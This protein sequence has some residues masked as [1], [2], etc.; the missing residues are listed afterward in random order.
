MSLR[1]S[2][3]NSLNTQGMYQMLRTL[4]AAQR[5]NVAK[6]SQ[7]VEPISKIS[8]KPSGSVQYT[9]TLKFVQKYGKDMSDVKLSA[10]KLQSGNPSNVFSNTNMQSSDSSVVQID[11]AFR[12]KEG[13]SISLQVESLAQAQQNKSQSV[14]ASDKAADGSSMNFQVASANG[15]NIQVNVSD[16]NQDGTKKTN[17]QMYQEAADQINSSRNSGV[18]A[19]VAKEN[20]KVSLVLTSQKTGESN[21]FTVQGQMG[22]AAG[23][24]AAAVEGE[25][26]KYTV[27]QNGKTTSRTSES[28]RISLDYGRVDA[29]LKGTGSA[30]VKTGVDSDQIVSA[31]KDLAKNYNEAT[32][33]LKENASRGRGTQAQYESFSRPIASDRTLKAVGISYDKSGKMQVDEK[34]LKKALTDDFE[35]TKDI[36]GGQFGIADRISQRA[37]SAISTSSGRL[38]DQDISSR[39][40]RNQEDVFSSFRYLDNFSGSGPYSMGNYYAVGLMLNT[41]G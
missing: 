35:G 40:D 7:S 30:Q 26:A 14:N 9:D 39:M 1:I 38:V 15:R 28:N 20:G 4:Q 18:S 3:N 2:G 34:A 11:Q 37:D 5:A 41:L 21:G 16:V 33:L 17:E 31:V 29:T 36:L 8:R 25:N 23:A 19:S 27:T 24:E 13:T 22:A 6:L 12:P 32:D 10:S